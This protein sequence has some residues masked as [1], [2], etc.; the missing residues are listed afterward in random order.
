MMILLAYTTGLRSEEFLASKWDAIEF[1]GPE[2]KIRIERTVDRKPIRESAKTDNFNA[3]VPMCDR[4]GAALLYFSDENPSVNGWV[5]GSLRTGRHFIGRSWVQIISCLPCGA[6]RRHSG[7][8][9][10]TALQ[11]AR[12]PRPPPCL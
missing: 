6:W 1:D 3:P 8:R 9:Y 10:L 5:F 12:I 7:R 4:L 2:P 11:K